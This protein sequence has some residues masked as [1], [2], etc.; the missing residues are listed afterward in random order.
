VHAAGSRWRFSLRWL[1]A[2]VA[3]IALGLYLA[4]SLP[5]L[6]LIAAVMAPLLLTLAVLLRRLGWA[7]L[8]A[9]Y[10]AI[11]AAWIGC[12]ASLPGPAESLPYLMAYALIGP[13]LIGL[14][15]L[16]QQ[17]PAR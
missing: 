9:Y 8:A 4:S 14:A 6:S 1:M 13:C 12:E 16:E 15:W 17:R 3:I 2:L 10:L 5:V 11:L 7:R